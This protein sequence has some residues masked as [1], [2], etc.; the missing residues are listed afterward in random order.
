MIGLDTNVLVR[1]FTQDNKAE[2]QRANEAIEKQC[3]KDNPG[4]IHDIVL[5]ELVWVLAS[6]YECPKEVISETLEK[7]L[8]SP[9]LRVAH[10]SHVWEAIQI[11][12][13]TKADFSD[14]L[15]GIKNSSSGCR[16]TVTFDKSLKE[17]T[18]FSVI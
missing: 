2:A 13:K 7:I 18:H 17:T 14:C 16:K 11:F 3:S 6:C 12:K 15:L 8:V 5:C 9:Q 1:Y 10:R 4:F